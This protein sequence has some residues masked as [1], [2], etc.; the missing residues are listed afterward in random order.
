MSKKL[1][2]LAIGLITMVAMVPQSGAVAVATHPESQSASQ[3]SS[4]QI[5]RYERRKVC[6]IVGMGR[7]RRR[8]CR[9]VRR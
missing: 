2:S 9:Y 6:R 3:T 5:A 8:I 7:T 4:G 1:I